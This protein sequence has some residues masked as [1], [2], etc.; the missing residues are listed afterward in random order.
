MTTTAA[1]ADTEE[2]LR[3]AVVAD[4]HDDTVRLAYADL[5]DECGQGAR[6]EFIRAQVE[7][8]T[9]LDG[10][11]Y[12]NI[13]CIDL[14]C[15]PDDSRNQLWKHKVLALHRRADALLAAHEAEWTRRLTRLWGE[16]VPVREV[17]WTYRRGFPHRVTCNLADVFD[18]ET[19]TALGLELVAREPVVEVALGDRVAGPS[20]QH[21]GMWRWY[22]GDDGEDIIPNVVYRELVGEYPVSEHGRSLQPYWPDPQSAADALAAAAARVLR[23]AARLPV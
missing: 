13:E 14:Y 18:G 23:R 20:L 1:P 19:P 17:T 11:A 3:R 7:L 21:S 5:M 12:Q 10:F 22:I 15:D 9:L 4:P 6:A 16:W 8:H 2:A